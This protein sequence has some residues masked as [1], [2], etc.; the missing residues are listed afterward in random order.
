VWSKAATFQA[1]V[2]NV[3]AVN[4]GCTAGGDPNPP[5]YTALQYA[6]TCGARFCAGLG[7]S[8]GMIVEGTGAI[9]SSSPSKPLQVDCSK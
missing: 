7:F 8:F 5:A 1:Y 9:Y 4:A 6:V 2:T 3:A